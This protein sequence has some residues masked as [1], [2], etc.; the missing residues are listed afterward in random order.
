MLPHS[1]QPDATTMACMEVRGGNT[2]TEEQLAAQGLDIWVLSIPYQ[3][4]PTNASDQGGDVHFITSCATGRITR[5]LLADVSGHGPEVAATARKL[6]R[7]MSA[8]SNHIEQSALVSSVNDNFMSA[9]ADP[10]AGLAIFATALVA[11]FF[12]PTGEIRLSTAGHPPPILYDSVR[13]EWRP[14]L[15]AD[16]QAITE[17]HDLPLGVLDGVTYRDS[18]HMLADDDLVVMYTDAITEAASPTGAMLGIGGLVKLL[19]QTD[20]AKPN[21]LITGLMAAVK[22]HRQVESPFDDD[23]SIVVLKRNALGKR[24]SLGMGLSATWRLSTNALR[25]LTSRDITL[26]LPEIS[27]RAIGGAFFDRFNRPGG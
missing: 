14:F 24:S 1:P 13:G 11:T 20:P 23:L 9:A 18:A 12:A 15:Q 8:H 21:E 4:D 16:D 22:S 26:T 7:L 3:S 10:G 2:R 6:K 27:P 5:L 17:P 25:S 19:D